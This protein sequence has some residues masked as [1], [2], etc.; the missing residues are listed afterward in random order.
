MDTKL[1]SMKILELIEQLNRLGEQE[2]IEAKTGREVGKSI[3]QTICAFS[4]E[5]NLRGG[6]LLLGLQE[7]HHQNELLYQIVGVEHPKKLIEDI[8]SQ[9]RTVFNYPITV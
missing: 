9:C 5:P 8:V 3:L 6:Y 2:K 7:N 1:H 4:N